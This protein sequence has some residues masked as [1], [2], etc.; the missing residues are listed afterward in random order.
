MVIFSRAVEVQIHVF[1]LCHHLGE[2]YLIVHNIFSS[3]DTDGRV[4]VTIA[5]IGEHRQLSSYIEQ[6]MF[7]IDRSCQR[8]RPLDTE[9]DAQ[10]FLHPVGIGHIESHYEVIIRRLGGFW[11]VRQGRELGGDIVDET[12]RQSVPVEITFDIC[13]THVAPHINEMHILVVARLHLQIL[14][15]IVTANGV[16]GLHLKIVEFESALSI[17]QIVGDEIGIDIGRE[18]GIIPFVG[19]IERLRTQD[20]DETF[21]FYRISVALTQFTSQV[22]QNIGVVNLQRTGDITSVVRTIDD[23]I[24]VGVGL[25]FQQGNIT[26]CRETILVTLDIDFSSECSQVIVVQNLSQ[27]NRLRVQMPIKLFIFVH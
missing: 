16:V 3:S 5:V 18:P 22:C 9:G 13:F 27:K 23:N 4:H 1:F 7:I 20:F 12:L 21:Q 17:I 8:E 19:K 25:V 11:Q 6:L 14:Q 2:F 10:Q 26:F 15:E 24:M